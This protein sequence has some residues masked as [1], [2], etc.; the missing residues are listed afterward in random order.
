V[1]SNDPSIATINTND[2]T[3]GEEALA[4]FD[5]YYTKLQDLYKECFLETVDLNG[6]TRNFFFKPWIAVAVAK[7]CITK[8]NLCAYKASRRGESGYE[9][10]KKYI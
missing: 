6:S 5:N 4:Q 7:S 1:Y 10:E 8:N 2:N 3:T 9:D